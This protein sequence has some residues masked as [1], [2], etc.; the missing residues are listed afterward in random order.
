MNPFQFFQDLQNHPVAEV[1]FTERQLM[2]DSHELIGF[3][4][5]IQITKLNASAIQLSARDW[6]SLLDWLWYLLIGQMESVFFVTEL[7]N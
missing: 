3:A 4:H 7:P 5:F 2:A 1:K 6:E